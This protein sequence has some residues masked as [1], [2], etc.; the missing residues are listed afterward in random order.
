MAIY[1]LTPPIVLLIFLILFLV[2]SKS[3][4]KYSNR[5]KGGEHHLDAYACGQRDVKHY[6]NP[7]YSQFFPIAFFFTIMHVLVLV[8]ATAPFDAPIL[9]IIFILSGLLSLIIIFKR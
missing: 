6:V 9:P 2:G 8:V 7:D 3:V 4:S 1:L 5:G